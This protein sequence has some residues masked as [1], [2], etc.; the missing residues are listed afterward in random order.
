V[1]I[2][3]APF[4]SEGLLVVVS[5]VDGAGKTTVVE[6]TAARLAAEG[7]EVVV[8]R[9]PTDWWRNEP[10]VVKSVFGRGDAEPMA[11][12]AVAFLAIADRLDHQIR[13]L[14]PELRRGAVI[15]S[16]RYIYSLFGYY[17]ADQSLELAPLVRACEQLV[18]PSVGFLM[19]VEPELALRRVLRRD[20]ERPGQFD[21]RADFVCRSIEAFRRL[22][23]ANDL[24][25][26]DASKTPEHN[27]S[28][29]LSLIANERCS[30]RS[31]QGRIRHL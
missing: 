9:Q 6:G 25:R 12:E 31:G 16:D 27:I 17:M 28:Q 23:A 3:L 1:K 22:A 13:V 15:L 4:H 14:I 8:T 29:V 21:Q 20:G 7:Y 19:D 26:L 18:A 11:P 10:R 24:H 30:R 2:P 5:G